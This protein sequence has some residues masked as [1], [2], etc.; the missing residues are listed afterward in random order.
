MGL[1]RA[2]PTV[3]AEI[4][5]WRQGFR[6]VAGIDEAGR[7]PLAG[8]V[9]AGAVILDPRRAR[10]WWAELRD[11]KML[12]A[13]DRE[14][15][16]AAIRDDCACAVGVASH[17]RI[18]DLGLVAATKSAMR[19]AIAALP[20]RPDMLL[21]DAVS[22]PEYRHRAI[23][24]GDALVASIA[25]ASILAKVARDV[26]MTRYHEEFPAYGFGQNKGYAT[27]EH[28]RALDEHGPCPIH[29]RLFAPVRAAVEERTPGAAAVA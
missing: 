9:V 22:L 23:I 13:P 6:F 10:A 5:A 20:C 28:K 17:A 21:I 16:A 8:P 1:F 7:G 25:A 15:L 11:S 24:H 27:P 14:R 3:S 19:R 2:V 12:T 18:D 4:A 26:I 29:R